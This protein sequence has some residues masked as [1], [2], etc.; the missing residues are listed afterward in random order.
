MTVG[1]NQN[2]ESLL[3]R[4]LDLY[5]SDLPFSAKFKPVAHPLTNPCHKCGRLGHHYSCGKC[6][7][8]SG[9]KT[10]PNGEILMN[11]VEVEDCGGALD[12]QVGGNHYKDM[13]IQPIE[14]AMANKLNACQTHALKYLS[15]TK[16]D[17]TKRIEDRKKAI[18]CLEIEIQHLEQELEGGE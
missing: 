13:V 15:R 17:L 8:F 18:H 3:A 11:R 7:R 10:L 6:Y 1:G 5:D 12:T 14:Y 9:G 4:I 16:G 2:I